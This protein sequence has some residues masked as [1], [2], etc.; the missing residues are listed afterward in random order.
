MSRE[1]RA[2]WASRIVACFTAAYP[3]S[4]HYRGG[5]SLRLGDWPKR[6]PEIAT[7]RQAL[8]D[9]VDAMEELERGGVLGLQWQR[10]QRGT[11]LRAACLA[12]PA[13]LYRLAGLASPENREGR[14][15]AALG[16]LETHGPGLALA[17]WCR[18]LLAARHPLPLDEPEQLPDIIR[19]ASLDPAAGRGLPL[20]ALSIRLYRDSKRLEAILPA[21]DRLW[22]KVLGGS[23]SE[24]LGLDRSWPQASL[25]LDGTLRRRDGRTLWA[26]SP[27][28]TL[29]L[30]AI[31][32]LAAWEAAAPGQARRF[33]SIENKETFFVLCGRP[34]AGFAGL[35]LVSG[36]TNRAELA[37]LDF[38]LAQG[39][40]WHHSGDLDPDGL[41]IAQSLASRLGA[42]LRT[43]R[44]EAA[45]HERW[46]LWGKPLSPA[47][48]S[49][50]DRV[51]LPELQALAQAIRASGLGV[52]QEVMDW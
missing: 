44:M 2:S 19:L 5:A 37:L 42:S 18:G 29:G 4:A 49:R 16:Q 14:L 27:G 40:E 30:P 22:Q 45:D 32:E 26:G 52:E 34:P 20:R 10:G 17:D 47:L 51:N 24:H 35:V 41:L 28:I 23:A 39:L 6:F 11:A 46:R 9:F 21:A 13:A 31:S 12:D 15:L 7:D 36:Y 43:W 50:L 8:D 1:A 25:Q 33:L 48:L 38:L 3:T